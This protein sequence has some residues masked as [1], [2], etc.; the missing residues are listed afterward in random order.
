LNSIK[1][2]DKKIGGK[3]PCFIIAEAGVNHNGELKL[4]KKLVDAAKEAGADAIKFQTFKA[5][6]LVTKDANPAY[7]AQKNLQ[8]QKISQQEMIKKY[9]L[10]YKQFNEIKKYC[11]SKNIIFLSSPH[12]FDAI[13]FLEKLVPAFKF[14]S[15]DLTNI[16]ALRYTA[17][18]QKPIILGTGMA[19]LEEVE[20]AVNE[21]KA[22]KN[23]KIVLLH[24]TTNYPC[25]LDEVNLFAMQTMKDEIG[26]IVGF[27][28]HTLG[29]FACIIAVAMGAKVIEKHI[30]LD[31]KMPGPDHKASIEPDEL[32]DLIK[33]IRLVEKVLGSAEKKPTKSEEKIKNQVRKSIISNKKISKGETIKENMIIIKRPGIGLE[34]NEIDKIIGKKALKDINQDE[35][36]TLD[37]VE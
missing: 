5:E 31:R 23:D 2:G 22:Q 20:F 17:K 29:P 32:K 34:P 24:C 21:I 15:G 25:P 4:A 16:P 35:I 18:K 33:E 7:Y 6:N 30:T 9:E 13:D 3:N 36:I 26:S 1:I 11:D 12:S 28:D 19:T 10:N 8:N 14:G 27:S 37:M